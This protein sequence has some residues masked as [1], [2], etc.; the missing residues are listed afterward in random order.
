M[1][2]DAWRVLRTFATS[3][4]QAADEFLTPARL[5]EVNPPAPN[6]RATVFDFVGCCCFSLRLL[7]FS[8]VYF[9]E[10]LVLLSFSAILFI[11]F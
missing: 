5:D 11:L 9:F 2:A 3:Y 8:F 7:I 4:A 6:R 1:P 10:S